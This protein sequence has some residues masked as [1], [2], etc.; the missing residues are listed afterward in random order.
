MDVNQRETINKKYIISWIW[1]RRS[2]VEA[3][4]N[5]ITDRLGSNRKE[6][7][8]VAPDLPQHKVIDLVYK[9]IHY[10]NSN[11]ENLIDEII[12][13]LKGNIV[14][15]LKKKGKVSVDTFNKFLINFELS[16]TKK[17]QEKV[18]I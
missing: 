17:Q 9:R 4:F 16:P 7:F 2:D 6:C 11:G 12:E 1:P 5:K 14:F 15:D 8:F 10:I 3:I 13:N 18:I